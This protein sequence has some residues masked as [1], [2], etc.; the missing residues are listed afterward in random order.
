M[1]VEHCK[2]KRIDLRSLAGVKI[3]AVGR[4][5]AGTLAHAGIIPDIIPDKFTVADLAG[6]MA[7]KTILTPARC[8][9]LV[10]GSVFSLPVS[11]KL[12]PRIPEWAGD[13]LSLA[14]LVTGLGVRYADKIISL[15]TVQTL[16]RHGMLLVLGV[17]P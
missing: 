11:E 9:F 3:A 17:R 6:A 12:R 8:A 15:H 7:M 13:L 10:M 16:L 14:L 5:T 1:F 2:E 4:G